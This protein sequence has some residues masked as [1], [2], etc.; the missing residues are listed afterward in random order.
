MGGR[1]GFSLL[2]GIAFLLSGL[3]SVATLYAQTPYELGGPVYGY[4]RDA[5]T[6]RPISGAQVY[7]TMANQT[8]G[9]GP[10]GVSDSDGYYHSA[11]VCPLFQCKPNQNAAQITVTKDGYHTLSEG[12]W[13]DSTGVSLNVDLVPSRLF[14]IDYVNPG[15]G[16]VTNTIKTTYVRLGG[17]G[18]SRLSGAAGAPEIRAEKCVIRIYTY[19]VTGE[20]TGTEVPIDCNWTAGQ[21]GTVSQQLWTYLKR[22][23]G[24][25]RFDTPKAAQPCA[26]GGI[27]ISRSVMFD[28]LNLTIR[29]NSGVD[30]NCQI[31]L[32]TDDLRS[33]VPPFP[34]IAQALPYWVP[35]EDYTLSVSSSN[36]GIAYT[37]IPSIREQQD[38][39]AALRIA[40]AEPAAVVLTPGGEGATLLITGEGLDQVLNAFVAHGEEPVEGIKADAFLTTLETLRIFVHAGSAVTTASGLRLILETEGGVVDTGVEIAVNPG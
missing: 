18:V 20:R 17:P 1:T 32:E 26:D 30:S 39:P 25:Y 5:E 34:V 36:L 31:R 19:T 23:Y 4:V 11:A 14:T 9:S 7:I 22:T 8:P 24:A 3:A 40:E 37:A 29:R 12:F 35:L 16:T 27:S 6:G 15:S 38:P 10:Y 33:D 21:G 13:A 2:L 28:V